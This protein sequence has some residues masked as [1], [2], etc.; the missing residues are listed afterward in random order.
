MQQLPRDFIPAPICANI[1]KPA[2]RQPPI[3]NSLARLFLITVD[4][5]IPTPFGSLSIVCTSF[6]V[7]TVCGKSNNTMQR[8][9]T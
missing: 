6:C 3:G 7:Q 8:A 4:G 2:N 5:E 1:Y 9:V